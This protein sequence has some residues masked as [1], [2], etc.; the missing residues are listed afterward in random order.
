MAKIGKRVVKMEDLFRIRLCG[1]VMGN[2]NGPSHRL[3]NPKV[4]IKD[5]ED[6][7]EWVLT[8]R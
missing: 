8:K 6:K 7:E 5:L 2:E 1:G 4:A 3:R